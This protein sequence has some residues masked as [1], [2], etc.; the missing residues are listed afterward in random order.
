MS[1]ADRQ[2]EA[3]EKRTL[4]RLKKTGPKMKVSGQQVIKLKKIITAR[5]AKGK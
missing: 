4:R 3:L 2:I 5:L 1:N